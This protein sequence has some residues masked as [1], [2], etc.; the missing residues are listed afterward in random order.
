[1]SSSM[2]RGR[3]GEIWLRITLFWPT[4]DNETVRDL[5][6]TWTSTMIRGGGGRGGGNRSNITGDDETIRDCANAKTKVLYFSL[7]G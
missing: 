4:V 5:A 3:G 7:L 6:Y 2:I 1:M